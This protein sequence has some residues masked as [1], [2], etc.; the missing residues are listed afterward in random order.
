MSQ[1]IQNKIYTIYWKPGTW[2]T[3]IS[4]VFAAQ[5]PIIYSTLKIFLNGKKISNDIRS[6]DDLERIQFHP[7]KSIFIMDEG[8]V[9][10]NSRRSSS[11]ANM[12]FWKLAMLWRKKNMD[13]VQISQLERMADVYYRELSE[14]SICMTKPTFTWPNQLLFHYDIYRWDYF[15]GSMDL[16]MMEWSK[17]TGY[18]YDTLESW[19]ID[20][21][22]S[23]IWALQQAL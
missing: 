14:C 8:G 7:E 6:I 5:Y 23:N 2:K 22:S 1:V 18:S 17:E 19:R 20:L 13:I 12:E 10:N 3:W 11:D 9:N 4:V 15:E 16:D 21:K